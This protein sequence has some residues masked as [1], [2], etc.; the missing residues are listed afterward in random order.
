[1]PLDERARQF[2]G[3]EPVKQVPG[4]T[5]EH[6]SQRIADYRAKEFIN[7]SGT[8]YEDLLGFFLDQ[9]KKQN[10]LDD[11][12][13]GAIA[14]LTINLRESYGKPQNSDEAATW[15]AE[16]REARLAEFDAICVAMQNYYDENA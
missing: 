6:A 7:L 13:V 12:A 2:L 10:Y 9:K 4:Q 3:N 1:M 5:S 16:K 14:L 15:T 11:V 8:F